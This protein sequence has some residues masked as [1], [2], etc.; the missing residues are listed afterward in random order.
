MA[1]LSR[2]G[3][4]MTNLQRQLQTITKLN[5]YATDVYGVSFDVRN[6]HETPEAETP[7]IYIV[8]EN[9]TQ[10]YMPGK[11]LPREWTIGIYGVMRNR[12]QVE[13]EEL[14]SDIETC[15]Q[16]NQTLSFDGEIPG[17]VAHHRV[18]NITTDNQL[19]SQ[20]D[21]TL[22]F[23]LSVTFLYVQCVDNSR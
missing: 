14:I 7:V 23:K 13:M 9:T 22:L 12:T 1:I 10:N 4:I 17:P 8:D 20:I 11:T 6:W 18:T 3:R 15:L 5:G 16:A 2:R 21:G 19:F